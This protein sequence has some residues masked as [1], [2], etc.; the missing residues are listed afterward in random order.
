[1]GRPPRERGWDGKQYRRRD[2][3]SLVLIPERELA[4]ED[5][6]ARRQLAVSD[7]PPLQLTPVERGDPYSALD[8]NVFNFRA[9][10]D[11]QSHVAHPSTVGGGAEDITADDAGTQVRIVGAIGRHVHFGGNQLEGIGRGDSMPRKV[12]GLSHVQKDRCPRCGVE[13]GND[14]L[15]RQ[16]DEVVE[17]GLTLN[18]AKL[19]LKLRQKDACFWRWV[20]DDEHVG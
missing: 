2:D 11:T 5:Y 8:R 14:V 13:F 16:V 12:P 7:V 6:A 10:S 15:R 1:N 4:K 3:V 19:F 9:V 17:G 18:R 20:D